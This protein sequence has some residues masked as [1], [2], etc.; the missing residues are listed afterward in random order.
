MADSRRAGWSS[1]RAE[2]LRVEG[3]RWIYRWVGG[4]GGVGGERGRK[5]RGIGGGGRRLRAQRQRLGVPSRLNTGGD[6][7]LIAALLLS[8]TRHGHGIRTCIES[9]GDILLH[10]AAVIFYLQRKRK[11]IKSKSVRRNL[12][13]FTRSF[14]TAAWEK[15]EG[16]QHAALRPRESG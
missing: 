10:G 11:K 16:V 14:P 8:R 1:R 2:G 4:V 12:F 15:G 9:E 7:C 5:R 3:S 13:L 6:N